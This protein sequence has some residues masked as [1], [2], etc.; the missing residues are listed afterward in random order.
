M[1]VTTF[2]G[3]VHLDIADGAQSNCAEIDVHNQQ[4][5]T[6]EIREIEKINKMLTSLTMIDSQEL[7]GNSSCDQQTLRLVLKYFIQK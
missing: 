5:L 3:S 1:S 6:P 4:L 2:K 7:Q